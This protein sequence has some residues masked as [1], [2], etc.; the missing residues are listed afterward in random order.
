M[1]K[2]FSFKE[3]LCEKGRFRAFG[4]CQAVW[5]LKRFRVGLLLAVVSVASSSCVIIPT[6]EHGLHSGHGE[7]TEAD[8][9]ALEVGKTTREEVL[10][11]LGEPS[12]S[13]N[14]GKIF[15]YDW[16]VVRGYAAVAMQTFIGAGEIEKDYQVILEFDEQGLLTRGERSA[17]G[18]FSAEGEK[19]SADY[20]Q[21]PQGKSAIFVYFP[22]VPGVMRLVPGLLF[23]VI[24]V[25]VD[26]DLLADL[27]NGGFALTILD[28]GMHTVLYPHYYYHENNPKDELALKLEPNEK[29][30]LRVSVKVDWVPNYSTV[31]VDVVPEKKALTE[32]SKTYR[33]TIVNAYGVVVH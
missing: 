14:E 32:L 11:R 28:P 33:S 20:L 26:K 5:G 9:V 19:F 27:Q 18:M 15:I 25:S 1:H 8:T 17:P 31:H 7:I 16:S 29:I 22:K 6:P 10:L 4:Y 12:A 21:I 24:P 3:G 30:F 2:Y 23:L 13:L